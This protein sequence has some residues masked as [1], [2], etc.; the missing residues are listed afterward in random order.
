MVCEFSPH[1]LL[2]VY[3]VTRKMHNNCRAY[4]FDFDFTLADSSEGVID[5]IRTALRHMGMPMRDD[6]EIIK[7]IGYSL[8][9]TLEILCG[10]QSLQTKDLFITYFKERADQVMAKKTYLYPYVEYIFRKLLNEG[11]K[12]GIISNKYRYCIEEI[13]KRE[14]LLAMISVIVGYEDVQ[15]PKPNQEGVIQVSKQIGLDI[16]DLIL[17]GDS[18]IDAKTAANSGIRF[19]GVLSGTTSKEELEQ[20]PYLSIIPDASYIIV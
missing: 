14:G 11:I 8:E 1:E 2:I 18:V 6:S 10:S 12:I 17:V 16:K 9:D 15:K 13:M 5:C 20:F 4:L 7:I 3:M 19:I